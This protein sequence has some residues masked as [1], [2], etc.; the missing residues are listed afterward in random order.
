M[1]RSRLSFGLLANFAHA[2]RFG[3]L[4]GLGTGSRFPLDSSPA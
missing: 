3:V 4:P 1:P 2:S